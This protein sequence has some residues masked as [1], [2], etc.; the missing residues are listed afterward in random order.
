MVGVAAPPARQTMVAGTGSADQ[1]GQGRLERIVHRCQTR[2]MG[3]V[4]CWYN[5]LRPPT[6]IMGRASG[7]LYQYTQTAG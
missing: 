7:M 6:L 2:D 3:I 1:L 4:Y 5:Q